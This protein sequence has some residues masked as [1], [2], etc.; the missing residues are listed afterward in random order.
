MISNIEVIVLFLTKTV[1]FVISQIIS[2]T[3]LKWQKIQTEQR[4]GVVFLY[5]FKR[6]YFVKIVFSRRA[7]NILFHKCDCMHDP[8]MN[9]C[10]HHQPFV[11]GCIKSLRDHSWVRPVLQIWNFS[12]FWRRWSTWSLSPGNSCGN[13]T[14]VDRPQ[15]EMN[16]RINST[17]SFISLCFHCVS[18]QSS[19]W[20]AV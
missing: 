19:C 11:S 14:G 8:H 15:G 9:K 10:S 16:E 7:G 3:S 18:I 5:I 4:T 13:V 12:D 20:F 17:I 2:S 6:Q 1:L